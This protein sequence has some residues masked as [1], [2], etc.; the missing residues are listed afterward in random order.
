MLL[1]VRGSVTAIILLVAATRSVPAQGTFTRMGKPQ[2]YLSGMSAD[3][4]VAVGVRSNFGPVFRWTAS[5]GVVN[6]GAVGFTAAISRDGKT[7]VSDA[8]D[9]NDIT[10]AAI[11]QGGTDW[12]LLGG[13]PNAQTC[14]KS[15][16]SA[17]HVS[18]DGSV[19]VGLA[20]LGCTAHAFRWDAANGMVDLGSLQGHDSRANA[21]SADGNVVGGWDEDPY[22]YAYPSW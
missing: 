20:W 17:W 5:G 1:N 4:T 13:L 21:V 14:D 9:A 6:I 22:A 2:T 10:S 12:K 18:G 15:L 19:I 8:G 3:G 11:W 7:I 16:S